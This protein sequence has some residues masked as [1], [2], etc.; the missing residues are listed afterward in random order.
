MVKLTPHKDT[1][2]QT[3]VKTSSRK[4]GRATYRKGTLSSRRKEAFPSVREKKLSSRRKLSESKHN[5]SNIESFVKEDSNDELWQTQMKK[6]ETKHD[7]MTELSLAKKIFGALRDQHHSKHVNM[8]EA[9]QKM[10]LD[11]GGEDP[12]TLKFVP[13]YQALQN[14]YF[15]RLVSKQEAHE[16]FDLVDHDHSG[17]IDFNELQQAFDYA[18]GALGAASLPG[19]M[20]PKDN[21]PTAIPRSPKKRSIVSLSDATHDVMTMKA[22]TVLTDAEMLEKKLAEKRL[23]ELKYRILDKVC[24]K[25]SRKSIAEALRQAYLVADVNQDGNLSYD[26]FADWLGEGPGGLGLGFS[27]KDVR[28]MTLACDKDLDG[29][30]DCHEFISTIARRDRPDPR[31]FLNECRETEMAHMNNEKKL[32]I[33]RMQHMRSVP[34]VPTPSTNDGELSTRVWYSD[35][36]DRVYENPTEVETKTYNK[37]NQSNRSNRSNRSETHQGINQGFK[38]VSPRITLAPLEGQND[39][40]S[41]ELFDTTNINDAL[42]Q[43]EDAPKLNVANKQNLAKSKTRRRPRQ[44]TSNIF[45]SIQENLKQHV[46]HKTLN[47]GMV[48]RL[49]F[50]D[51]GKQLPLKRPDKGQT[52]K[53]AWANRLTFD[54]IGLGSGGIDLNSSMYASDRDRLQE[55]TKGNDTNLANKFCLKERLD[56]VHDLKMA[57]QGK[58]EYLA[59]RKGQLRRRIHQRT[60]DSE[61]TDL[62]RIRSKTF[63]R[64]RFLESMQ[65]VEEFHVRTSYN[66][67]GL[68]KSPIAARNQAGSIC[69]F[70]PPSPRGRRTDTLQTGIGQREAAIVDW[71]F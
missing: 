4:S 12:G 46:F 16:I 66:T 32:E 61:S 64:L 55:I 24:Q 28:D 63:Q 53:P 70:R 47:P 42:D 35:D 27:E 33:E 29:G 21:N 8:F 43:M 15:D 3:D 20:T 17:S 40:S 26:E 51:F 5:T 34:R 50:E 1:V 2:P 36:Y 54:R 59:K 58:R 13:F 6:S 60:R 19:A 68:I 41:V 65:E 10:G 7:K 67:K 14:L 18:T 23:N 11:Y 9:F 22:K 45:H 30:I 44:R 37:M 48:S 52:F 38:T 39:A 31:S 56:S 69:L 25:N 62:A 57:R 49:N 71:R